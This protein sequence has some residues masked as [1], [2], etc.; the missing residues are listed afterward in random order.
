[1]PFNFQVGD[2]VQQ[3][4]H[5][6]TI[7]AVSSDGTNYVCAWSD[8]DGKQRIEYNVVERKISFQADK[9][10]RNSRQPVAD[11]TSNKRHKAGIVAPTADALTAGQPAAT[12]VV[13]LQSWAKSLKLRLLSC[14]MSLFSLAGLC[15]MWTTR[16]CYQLPKGC[17]RLKIS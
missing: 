16:S 14:L 1:M 10:I 3:D 13:H 8:G 15:Q 17:K 7:K 11:D 4:S 12:G 5:I 6:G 2:T 9:R